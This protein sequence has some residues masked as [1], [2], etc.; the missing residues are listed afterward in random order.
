M[1]RYQ[2]VVCPADLVLKQSACQHLD[3]EKYCASAI[4][5]H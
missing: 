1:M 3:R 2:V 4:L 5:K